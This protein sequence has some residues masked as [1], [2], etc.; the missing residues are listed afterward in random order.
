MKERIRGTKFQEHWSQAQLFY[1]SLS[2]I[3]KRHLIIALSFE[4]THCEDETVYT[5]AIS[6]LNDIDRFMA[7]KVALNV[8]GVLPDRPGRQNHGH[9]VKG[10]SQ[11]DFEPDIPTI[12]SRRI[13]ILLADGFDAGVVNAARAALRAAGAVP[14]IIGP[15]R[16]EIFPVGVT[17]DS[18]QRGSS[19]AIIAD[20]HY[21]SQRS[22]LFDA[23]FIPSGSLCARNLASNHRAIHW[24]LEAYGHLKAIGAIGEGLYFFLSTKVDYG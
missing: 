15:R 12:K 7:E 17:P 21:E 3:E 9:K 11:F 6:R 20:H 13:A 23:I 24:V 10:L 1:N 14:Y 16:G 22:T 5:T 2:E 19:E 4:L 8:G 18:A